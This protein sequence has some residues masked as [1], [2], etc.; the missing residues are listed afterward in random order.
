MESHHRPIPKHRLRN[1]RAM[2]HIATD[3]E[4]KLWR[5]LR[6]RQ[7]EAF[8]FR[9][10]VPIGNFIADLVCHEKKLIVEVDGGQHAE[11]A[12]DKERDQWFAEAG[13]Q[14]IR[15]WNN[16]VLKNPNGVLEALLSELA[17]RS[18]K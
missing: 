12:R 1:A 15:Y 14:V 4:K 9:R 8:K 3:A 6:S 16:D 2:R 17:A 13:Y 10:Q 5:L 11:N 7:L 18:A